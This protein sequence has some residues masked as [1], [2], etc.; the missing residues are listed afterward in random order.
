M[1]VE[2]TPVVLVTGA[3]DGLGRALALDLAADGVRLV[4]H[5]RNRDKLDVLAKEVRA[6]GGAEPVTAVADLA[7]LAQ[8]RQLAVDV[9]AA[10]DRLDVLVSNAGVGFTTSG[11]DVRAVSADGHELR[12]A[13]NHLAGVLLTV[14]LLPL[15]RRSAPARVVFLASIGQEALDPDDL[16]TENGFTEVLA[17]CRSKLAVIMA[18]AEFAARVPADEVTFAALHPATYMPTAMVAASGVPPVDTLEEGLAATKRLVLDPA[19]RGVT[20]RYFDKGVAAEPH[21][22][23]ADAAVRAELWTRSLAL[24]GRT[25]A[26]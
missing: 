13:V 20:G 6:L 25:G 5:G 10:T 9:A 11:D 8:V 22:Q 7:D 24:V 21:A 15:L 16:M 4:L 23:A 3:T 19:L 26:L 14:D 1:T 12:F 17:Y 18:T 2:A